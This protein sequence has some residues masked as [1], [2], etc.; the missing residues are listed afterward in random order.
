LKKW[1]SPLVEKAT[2]SSSTPFEQL[3]HDFLELPPSA[4]VIIVDNAALCDNVLQPIL[5]TLPNLEAGEMMAYGLDSE[6]TESNTVALV[7]LSFSD[8]LKYNNKY[9]GVYF[10]HDDMVVLIRLSHFEFA[11]NDLFDETTVSDDN[12]ED[13]VDVGRLLPSSLIQ[14]FES[15]QLVAIG[16]GVAHDLRLI[17]SQYDGCFESKKSTSSSE[18]ENDEDEDEDDGPQYLELQKVASFCTEHLG[19]S[20]VCRN[21]GLRAMCIRFLGKSLSKDK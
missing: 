20:K 12:N 21:M 4:N 18:N 17:C 13:N 3:E 1:G 16:V 15:R 11:H 19:E 2:M 10:Q 14:I 9:D 5:S 8:L 7:Q 6:W